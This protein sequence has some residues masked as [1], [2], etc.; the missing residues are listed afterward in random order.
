MGH[1]SFKLYMYGPSMADAS[2]QGAWNCF[3]KASLV[4]PATQAP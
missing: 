4:S 3:C 1:D 2:I